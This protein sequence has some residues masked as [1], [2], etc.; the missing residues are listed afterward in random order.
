MRTRNPMVKKHCPAT[1]TH[2]CSCLHP[3][4]CQ[5]AH[6]DPTIRPVVSAPQRS[7]RGSVTYPVQPTSSPRAASKNTTTKSGMVDQ[8]MNGWGSGRPKSS[9]IPYESN[10]RKGFKKMTSTYQIGCLILFAS[11][12]LLKSLRMPSRFSSR[13]TRM[14]AAVIGHTICSELRDRLIGGNGFSRAPSSQNGRARANTRRKKVSGDLFTDPLEIMD[15]E[16]SRVC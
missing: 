14:N 1:H 11:K 2:C 7:C 16:L 5:S 15:K 9:M 3:T 12:T 6:T 13:Y 10:R 8:G 4:T